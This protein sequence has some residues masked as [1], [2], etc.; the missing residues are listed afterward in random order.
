MTTKDLS[1]V[2][3]VYNEVGNL[4]PLLTEINDAL[5]PLSLD[6]EVIFIDDGSSD[7]STSLLRTPER[8][9]RHPQAAR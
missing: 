6:Y 4:R 3:P 2:V 8:P 5:R 9:G 7:G 1:I